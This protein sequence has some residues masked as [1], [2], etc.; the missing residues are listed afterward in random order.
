VS[1]EGNEEKEE[2]QACTI[3]VPQARGQLRDGRRFA[4]LRISGVFW[5]VATVAWKVHSLDL[6]FLL[7][8]PECDV[9]Q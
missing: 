7:E 6:Q 3:N 8:V 5:V 9:M 1:R 4:N 2:P